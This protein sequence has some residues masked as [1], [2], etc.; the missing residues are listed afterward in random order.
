RVD[1]PHVHT[2]LDGMKQE[3]TMHCFAHG[4]I[5][6]KRKRNITNASAHLHQRHF[7]LNNSSSLDKI[8]RIIVVFFDPSGNCKDV[9]IKNDILRS[10][11][12]FF[13][14]YLVGSFTHIYPAL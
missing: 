8:Y 4:I 11:S 6:A 3:H 10:V 13:S 7:L 12:Y 14:K 5:P 9:W 2:S 1:D